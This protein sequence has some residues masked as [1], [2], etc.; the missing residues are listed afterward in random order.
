MFER[1]A[2]LFSIDLRSLALVRVGIAAVVLIDVCRRI[3]DLFLFYGDGGVFPVSYAYTFWTSD[4]MWSLHLLGG[5]AP[6]LLTALFVI[7]TLAAVALLIGFYTRIATIVLWVLV[8]SLHNANPLILQGEDVL[9]RVTLFVS[10]F[11][12]LG[13]VYSLDRF[14]QGNR[15]AENMVLSGWTVAYLL[16]LGFLYFFVSIYKHS[17]EWVG[18]TAAYYALSLDQYA[19]HFGRYL[20]QFP[21]FLVFTT[22]SILIFQSLALFLL[23]SPVYTTV[24]RVV[25]VLGLM[26]MHASFAASMHLGMFSSMSIVALCGFLPPALWNWLEAQAARAG[27]RTRSA[28]QALS[29]AVSRNPGVPE[30]TTGAV[31]SLV[32][33]LYILYIFF[34]HMGNVFVPGQYVPFQ[35]GFET[36][37]K[38]IRIDQRWNLF[39]PYPYRHDGWIIVDA[40]RPDGSHVNLRTGESPV[41]FERPVV[42]YDTYPRPRWRRY[43][44]SLW[45]EN[46]ARYRVPYAQYLCREAQAQGDAVQKLNVLYMVEWTPVPGEAP[47]PVEPTSLIQWDCVQNT[48]IDVSTATSS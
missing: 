22:Y 32:G 15:L 23:F 38:I 48:Y 42:I 3:P 31:V 27:A 21:S 9:L 33:A 4:W 28:L 10:M 36:P 5:G 19:T 7:E 26:I 25:T 30:T 39:A 11:L 47:K 18:G 41:S 29:C 6:T 34:W 2:H 17:P 1:L 24:I 20:L 43:F 45:I 12:P 35:Y 46:N 13:A 8:V 16:Q 37:A 40:E 14:R 44:L